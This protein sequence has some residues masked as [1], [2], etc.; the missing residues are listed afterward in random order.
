MHEHGLQQSEVTFAEVLRDAGYATAI[1]GKWHLGYYKKYNPIHH[2]FD[3]FKGYVSGNVDF[4]SHVDQAGS[5]DWWQQ[6]ELKD[7]EGYVTHLI[8]KHAVDFIARHKDRPFCL[9]LPHEPPHYPYQGPNDKAFREV[10]K[11]EVRIKQSNEDVKRKY[12]EMVV[13]MDKGVGE[14]IAALKKH[15]LDKNTLVMFFSD[16]GATG[17]GS[18]GPLR[19]TKGTVWEGGHRV[20]C[21]AW[22]P[23]KI[24]AGEVNDSLSI[25]LDVFPT[26]VSLAGVEGKIDRRLDGVDLSDVLL[27]GATHRDRKLY[28]E[29]NGQQ[30]MRDGAWKLVK[31]AKGEKGATLYDLKGDIGEKN[32]VSKANAERF[33]RMMTEYEAWKKDVMDGA[34]AQ[35]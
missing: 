16:N 34:T 27:K 21:V 31:N 10:G 3:E 22:W 8:T 20:P 2:G 28:W 19:G 23:G 35:P 25:T 32:D 13:E 15:G 4:F 1:F 6:D 18:C 26:V 17:Q 29:F 12:R 9:Y 33:E 11:S 5:Q 24:K 14:V 30:A 7:E